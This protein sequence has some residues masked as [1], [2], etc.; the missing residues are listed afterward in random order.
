MSFFNVKQAIDLINFDCIVCVIEIKISDL[1]KAIKI[2]LKK[3]CVRTIFIV[4]KFKKQLQSKMIISIFKLIKIY[5]Y[6]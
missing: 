1:H 4:T 6:D 2:L 3:L 5:C